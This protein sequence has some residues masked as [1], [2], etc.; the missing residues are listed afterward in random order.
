MKA[1]LGFR[2]NCACV[3]GVI[4][5]CGVV[6]RVG[7]GMQLLATYAPTTNPTPETDMYMK[8]S[9]PRQIVSRPKIR[10]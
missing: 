9:K 2:S 6:L 8:S 5:V 10:C 7:V 4:A 1:T 3:T